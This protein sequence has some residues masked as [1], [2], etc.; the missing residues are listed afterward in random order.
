M[1]KRINILGVLLLFA[2][3]VV[4]CRYNELE[5]EPGVSAGGNQSK[6][7]I[8]FVLGNAASEV[9]QTKS[10]SAPVQANV[11]E[12][13]TVTETD[14]LFLLASVVDNNDPVF[15]TQTLDTKA[16]PV[17]TDNIG[18]FHVTAYH[19]PDV[20]YFNNLTLGEDDKKIVNDVAYYTMDYYWPSDTLDFFASNFMFSNP[21]TSFENLEEVV[22]NPNWTTKSS[23]APLTPENGFYGYD[24]AGNCVGSFSYVL[25]NPN[26]SEKRDAENQPDYVVAIADR[27]TE[28]TNNGVVQLD[29][30]HC[31]TAVV[32]KIGNEFLNPKGRQVKEVAVSGVASSGKCTYT[33]SNTGAIAFDWNTEGSVPETYRQIIS[34]TDVDNKEQIND[35]ELTFMLIPHAISEDAVVRI[36]FAMH[37]DLDPDSQ[38][39]TIVEKKIRD[40][41]PQIIE[42]R[43]LPGKKY[44]YTIA[45]EEKV[46]VT[47]TDQFTSANVKGNLQITNNGT[48]AAYVRAMIVGWWENASGVVV[49]PWKQSEKQSDGIFT[50]PGW[51]SGKT[52]TQADDGFYYYMRPL[53][54]G[55]S[56][57]KLFDTYELTAPPP[58]ADA[59]L[60]LTIVT[61]GVVHYRAA[62]AWPVQFSGATV[63]G[64][65][66]DAGGTY[67]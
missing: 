25:P 13:L 7:K 35:G 36:T 21:S 47:V 11:K 9:I 17:T 6:S 20:K 29:F 12:L 41:F 33:V 18:D 10:A 67:W 44:I 23:G 45:S 56:T 14:S 49:A 55:E 54:S 28:D 31:F 4:S 53:G 5:P 16:A 8:S 24:G 43:W 61:Q 26:P 34:D 60:V 19:S 46:D 27:I 15:P 52:W 57:D 30:A 65:T 66:P 62:E 37:T 32:F 58:T 59:R 22:A 2:V 51:G 39:E 42:R 38:H 64:F 1:I 40:L 3:A 48:A 50:V 63:N